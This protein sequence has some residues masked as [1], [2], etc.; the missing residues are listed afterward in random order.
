VYDWEHCARKKR[1]REKMGDVLKLHK[2]L[3]RRSHC[4]KPR[5]NHGCRFR[6]IPKL[7]WE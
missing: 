1:E 4:N 3:E 6:F 5:K 7:K 2:A